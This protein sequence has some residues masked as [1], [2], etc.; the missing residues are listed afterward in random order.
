M[1]PPSVPLDQRLFHMAGRVRARM[2]LRGFEQAAA[3]AR[4]V[5][6]QTLER[7]LIANRDCEIGRK[8]DF[9][10]LGREPGAFA[11]ALPLQRW[12]D[13]APAVERM[14]QGERRVLCS[15]PILFF[16]LS[17]GTT[18][19]SKFVP[20]TASS[21]AWQR[22]YY[23][24]INPAVPASQLPGGD[25]PHQGIS[26]L[27]AAGVTRKTEGGIPVALASANGLSRVRRI[28]PYLWTSPWTVF[29]VDDLDAS[30][31]LHALFGLR[32]RTAKFL[33]AVFAP[34]LLAWLGFVESR[35]DA[36]LA[37]IGGGRIAADLPLGAE[38]RRRLER[39]L[40]P[41]PA[42]AA[43]LERAVAPGFAGF[44]QRAWPWIRY[45]STVIT[46]PFAAAVP[47]L[48]SYLGDLPIHTTCWSASEGMLGL[49]LQLDRPE[50][51]V[52]CNGCAYFEFIPLDA[53]DQDQP[54]TRGLHELEQ[55]RQ[56]ELV[57][58][59]FAGLYRYRLGDIV[60]VLDF[61]H[62]APVLGFRYPDGLGARPRRREDQRGAGAGRPA[63]RR[64]HRHADRLRR[65]AGRARRAAALRVLRG[66]HLAPPRP[67]RLERSVGRSPVH[68]QPVLRRLP[69]RRAPPPRARGSPA[70][71]R[72]L[73]RTGAT[74]PH[75]EP[76]RRPQSAQD[77]APAQRR[78]L[79]RV[80]GALPR[81]LIG[82]KNRCV[83]LKYHN[84]FSHHSNP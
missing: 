30:W 83:I 64:G 35:W 3:D 74:P 40:E 27:S 29:E 82:R 36:L 21:F 42:R 48:R 51:Y 23:T 62:E 84:G 63:A 58:S 53:V 10:R 28:V 26:L 78:E 73:R 18:G 24:G 70:P 61:H 69:R 60:D 22:R 4:R 43:E 54:P 8:Y 55:G 57:L 44:V 45:A 79:A 59:N 52:L 32:T 75:A 12:A 65:V 1:R 34:H 72:L 7:I 31:Y 68:H 25:D 37:D 16:A 41:D 81:R 33:N 50:R 56:Y 19:N 38:Q 71:P 67:P 9:A 66:G 17:S 80:P 20:A 47:R 14:A 46:G 5:N 76:R 6:V 77:P 13:V 49:N 11:G 39:T 15:E 2:M